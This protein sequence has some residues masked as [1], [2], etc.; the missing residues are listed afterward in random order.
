MSVC[1]ITLVL[2]VTQDI[3]ITPKELQLNRV[4]PLNSYSLYF[5][6]IFRPFF[7]KLYIKQNITQTLILPI[8]GIEGLTYHSLNRSHSINAPC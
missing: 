5:S 1:A 8:Y 2:Y 6:D 7:T 4:I 3:K